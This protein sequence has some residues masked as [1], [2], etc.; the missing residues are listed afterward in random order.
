VR[1][2]RERERERER[3][4][5]GGKKKKESWISD[6]SLFVWVV[7]ILFDFYLFDF[8]LFSNGSIGE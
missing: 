2:E 8:W 1:E 3:D 5:S 6:L 7:M 4:R